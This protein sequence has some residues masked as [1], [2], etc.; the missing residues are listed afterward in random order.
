MA[1]SQERHGDHQSLTPCPTFI[2]MGNKLDEYF[3]FLSNQRAPKPKKKKKIGRG[4]S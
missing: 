3:F 2:T 1:K 4:Q